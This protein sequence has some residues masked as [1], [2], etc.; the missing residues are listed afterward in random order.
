MVNVESLNM[1]GSK[2]NKES[3]VEE[4]DFDTILKEEVGQWGW[5]QVRNI[6]LALIA[7]VFLGWS[8]NLYVFTAARI[9]TRC[10]I[11]ECDLEEPEFRPDWLLNAVPGTSLDSFDNCQRF[12][13]SSDAT[14]AE[15][16]CPAA[17]FDHEQL[18]KCQRHLYQSTDTIV[19]DFDLACNEWRRT[20]VGTIR[21]SGTIFAQTITGFISDRWGRR[22]ALVFNAF[23]AAWM[24]ILRSFSNSYVIFVIAEFVSSTLGS[25]TFQ[26]SYI[27]MMEL[28]IPKNRVFVGTCL[29]TCL[30]LSLMAL[31]FIA[32]AVPYWRNL[33]LALYIPQLLTITYLWVMS[34][35]IRWY[36]SKGRYED[37]EK[38]LKNIARV[39]KKK[40][41]DKY[42]EALRKKVE[43]VRANQGESRGKLQQNETSLIK[44]LWQHKPVLYRCFYTPFMW[45]TF[46]LIYHGLTINAVDISGNKY[47]NYIAVAGA[48]IPG[49]WVSLLLLDKIGRKPVLIA[50]Y[51]ICAA[52][53]LVFIY[54]PKNHYVL[55]LSV[56]MVGASCSGAML[57]SLYI[58]TAELYPTRYRHRLF[59]FSSTIGRF[60]AVLAPLTPA[61]GALVWD[62]FPFALFAGCACAAGALVLLTPETRG[63]RLPDTMREAADLG[64]KKTR[65]SST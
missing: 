19:Y 64:R 24:G 57:T 61:L 48:Q 12:G 45:I 47:V 54:V 65:T 28:V 35:S 53:Q 43:E 29:N 1:D 17:W 3:A 63:V 42:L 9:P 2:V 50:A 59:G 33:T 58:Y 27:L 25:A 16:A 52:C 46:T 13:N 62:K 26:T 6:I 8:N 11:L 44:V 38:A 4:M 39:N 40:I 14:V 34:E 20:L 37:T 15:G 21:L 23:N 60:G 18:Q 51:W 32:W 49:F 30:S 31:G 22:T 55:S 7:V 56:Y 36:I 41:S 5:F 10:H